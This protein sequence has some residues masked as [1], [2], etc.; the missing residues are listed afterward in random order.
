MLIESSEFPEAVRNLVKKRLCEEWSQFV[1]MAAQHFLS[2]NP[3]LVQTAME[4]ALRLEKKMVAAGV[5]NPAAE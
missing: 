4:G 3:L 2:D 1:D 5:K